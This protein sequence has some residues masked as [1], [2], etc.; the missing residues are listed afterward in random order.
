MIV[1][2]GITRPRRGGRCVAVIA[3]LLG[4]VVAML[5][6]AAPASAAASGSWALTGAMT[7]PRV[8]ATATLLPD[9]KVLVAGGFTPQAGSTASADCT[10]RPPAPG[11]RPGR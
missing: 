8:S 4:L 6:A 7:S 1:T 3:G 5:A 11:R 10:I 9:G 2:Q